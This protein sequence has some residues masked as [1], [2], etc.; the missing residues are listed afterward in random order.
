MNQNSFRSPTKSFT[1][2][3]AAYEGCQ[4]LCVCDGAQPCFTV[5]FICTYIVDFFYH[6]PLRFCTHCPDCKHN[7][8]FYSNAILAG[9]LQML[10]SSPWY[11]LSVRAKTA[12]NLMAL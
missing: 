4:V 8:S 3:L 7:F 5:T 11:W 1:L 2:A 6:M 12:E 10:P 9:M